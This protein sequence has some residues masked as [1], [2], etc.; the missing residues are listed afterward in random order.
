MPASRRAHASPIPLDAPVTRTAPRWLSAAIASESVR[1]L[2]GRATGG[3]ISATGTREAGRA[4]QGGD[5][6]AGLNGRADL[7][8]A[9]AERGDGRVEVGRDEGEAPEEGGAVGAA[10][11]SIAS[12]GSCTTSR[13][14]AP[15][16]KNACR[17]APAGV[18]SS[19]MRRRSRPAAWSAATVRSSAGVIATTWSSAVT[20]LGCAGG[21]AGGVAVRARRSAARRARP[22]ST[23]AQRPAAQPSPAPR[24]ASRI[25]TLADDAGVAV[26][27]R[28]RAPPR[29]SGSSAIVSSAGPRPAP[30]D[31]SAGPAGGAPVRARRQP[32]SSSAT[33]SMC[34]VCGNMSTGRTRRRT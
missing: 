16:R 2:A 26:D 25:R 33:H 20:P 32:R 3:V 24:P 27:A 11:R 10:A 9:L 30:A 6:A 17:G 14:A 22:L 34:G 7:A 1:L 21:A 18:G 19:R 12:S 13:M 23:L 28:T 8:D 15:R 31:G 4:A 5:A 29:R